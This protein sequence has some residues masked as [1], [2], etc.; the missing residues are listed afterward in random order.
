[1]LLVLLDE[2]GHQI[3]ANGGDA[4][5]QQSVQ[6]LAVQVVQF[7]VGERLQQPQLLAQLVQRLDALAKFLSGAIRNC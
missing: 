5:T 3:G 2:A 4:L 7:Q 1:M 6:L